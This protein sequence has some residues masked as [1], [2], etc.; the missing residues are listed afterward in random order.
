MNGEKY[1]N[2]LIKH[3]TTNQKK[4]SIPIQFQ[5]EQTSKE[6][7]LP[8]IK[9]ALYNDKEVNLQRRHKNP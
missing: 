9:K 2:M 1:T 4:G 6:G 7:K 5:T 3:A 8:Q